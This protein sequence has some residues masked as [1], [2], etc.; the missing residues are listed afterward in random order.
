LIIIVQLDKHCLEQITW[1]IAVPTSASSERMCIRILVNP[2]PGPHTLAQWITTTCQHHL[3]LEENFLVT[4][5]GHGDHEPGANSIAS[6]P[7]ELIER[8]H[9]QWTIVGDQAELHNPA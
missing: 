6:S 9:N 4:D 8:M 1:I 7:D 3:T 2:E 5:S